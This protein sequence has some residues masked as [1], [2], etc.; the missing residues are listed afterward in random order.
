MYNI[1]YVDMDG[2]IADFNNA[3]KKINADVKTDWTMI[4]AVEKV[5]QE[6]PNL[7]LTLDLIPGAHDSIMKLND[8]FDIYFL[9]TPMWSLPTS[10]TD[11]R[12]WIEKHFGH[13]FERRLIL[14]HRKDLNHGQFLVDDSKRHG[15][16]N[17]NGIH[18]HFGQQP[19]PTWKEVEEYL[20]GYSNVP[21]IK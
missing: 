14:T 9:S 12:L 16:D 20:M 6:N 1:L 10:F 7:F 4:E 3:I 15:V 8:H 2:V 21:P 18:I 17:F 5:C 19:F 11:K 13:K